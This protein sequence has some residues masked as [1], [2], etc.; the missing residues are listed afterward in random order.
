M[1][2]SGVGEVAVAEAADVCVSRAGSG[3][4]VEVDVRVAVGDNTAAAA[5]VEIAEVTSITGVCVFVG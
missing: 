2:E 1:V 3:V 5:G 4:S